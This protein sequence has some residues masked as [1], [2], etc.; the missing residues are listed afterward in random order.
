[1]PA[2]PETVDLRLV[3]TDMDGPLVDA[4]S[5]LPAGLDD[6]VTASPTTL[7]DPWDKEQIGEVC[8]HAHQILTAADGREVID[9]P[10]TGPG[11]PLSGEIQPPPVVLCPTR[12]SIPVDHCSPTPPLEQ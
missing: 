1:M 6:A 10:T 5:R 4:E 9:L 12:F 8:G 7:S 3:V 11:R 2:L